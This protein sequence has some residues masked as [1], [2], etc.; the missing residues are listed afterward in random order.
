MSERELRKFETA[1]LGPEHARQ[2]ALVRSAK[3]DGELPV[4]ELNDDG[5]V[6]ARRGGRRSRTAAG[7]PYSTF[8]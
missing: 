2:H 5:L 6:V 1:V 7:P 4:E 8:R 3:R